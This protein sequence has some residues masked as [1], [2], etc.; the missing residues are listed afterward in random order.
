M[1]AC[2]AFCGLPS[3]TA[4]FA[5]SGPGCGTDDLYAAQRSTLELF[6]PHTNRDD[7]RIGQAT[8]DLHVSVVSFGYG[9][10]P[11]QLRVLENGRAID[12]RRIVPP[13]DGSP[14]DEVF[15]VSPTLTA[16]TVYTA[17]IPDAGGEA[18]TENNARSVLVSPAGRKRRL[19]MV[20]GAPGFEHSFIRRELTRDPAF[21]VDSVARKGKNEQGRDTF[22][23]QADAARTPALLSG[24][25]TR[26][27]DLYAYDAVLVA[28]VEA[29]FFTRA[30]LGLLADF[31]AERGGGLG[32]LGARSFAQRGL[33]GTPIEA[34]LPIELDDRRG[35]LARASMAAGGGAGPN[36]VTLTA[37][38]EEHPIMRIGAT[39]EETRRLW[40]A[41]PPLASEAALGGPRPGATVLAVTEGPNGIVLPLVAVQRYGQGRSFVFA[42][43]ASWR[44]KML[45]P[46]TDRTHELFWRQAARWLAMD[47]PDQVAITVPASPE[48]QDLVPVDVDVR[49]KAFAPVGGAAVAAT[50]TGPGGA[51]SPLTV[52]Q[53]ASAPG[54]YRGAFRPDQPGLYRVHADAKQGGTA[55]GA[56]D[57]WFYVGGADREF[58][59]PRLN[60]GFL[61][62]VARASGG[63][64]VLPAD[65]SHIADWLQSAEPQHA[66]P[67]RRDL[68]HE[69]WAYAIVVSLLA[70]EWILR[71]R[72]GLR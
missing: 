30:Q 51:A 14:I 66:A 60:E 31:V 23:V 41:L 67:E 50:L 24:F 71:R 35:G 8:V 55:I 2:A 44:W 27:E 18:V 49:D 19:L 22:F 68:W 45:M 65:A 17:D 21:E 61:R 40:A 11:F 20:E 70:A 9:R 59:D 48:P 54:R 6:Q 43:E 62:R 15:T 33:T 16:P 47:A 7:P 26:A 12:S 25:P 52:R 63:R 37:D 64:Y 42:G 29:D 72:W 10:A 56:A 57:R 39:P 58:A 32:V 28:N 5:R 3:A 13:A 46:S 34:A 38:G 53:Q 36:A 4:E 1:T 69:P